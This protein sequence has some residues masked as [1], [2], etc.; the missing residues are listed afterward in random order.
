MK[1][2]STWRIPLNMSGMLHHI[3]PLVIVV[4]F[5]V[6]GV[7]YFV[8]S[9]AATTSPEVQVFSTGKGGYCLTANTKTGPGN[10]V[11]WISACNGSAGQHWQMTAR[12]IN[13]VGTNN[14]LAMGGLPSSGNPIVSVVDQTCNGSVAQQWAELNGTATGLMYNGRST[15]SRHEC[16]VDPNNGRSSA[17]SVAATECHTAPPIPPDQEWFNA[18]YAAGSTGTPVSPPTSPTPPPTATAECNH[19]TVYREGSSGICVAA[20]QEMVN[21]MHVLN[22]YNVLHK[23]G[24]KNSFPGLSANSQYLEIDRQFGGA[25]MMAVE[26]AQKMAADKVDGAVGS[27]T[28]SSLCYYNNPK[29]GFFPSPVVALH[30]TY[31][32]QGKLGYSIGC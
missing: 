15:A 23:A 6:L 2:K 29:N 17:T 8:F 25:T 28:W 10:S 12:T 24:S 16:L 20:I 22:D 5:G 19:N 9:N 11:A 27:E 7:G 14:C 21:G 1:V 30:P 18:S 3:V 31:A 26:D 32:A 13:Q 4:L